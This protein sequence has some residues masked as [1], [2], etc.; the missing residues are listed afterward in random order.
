M[1]Y[2]QYTSEEAKRLSI[3]YLGTVVYSGRTREIWVDGKCI[4]ANFSQ[5]VEDL[6]AYV[7]E[8]IAKILGSEGLEKTLDT[9]KEIQDELLKNINYTVAHDLGNSE[10]EY[11]SVIREEYEGS[12]DVAAVYRDEELNVVATEDKD[13]NIVYEEGYG[14]LER[15]NVIDAL[16]EKINENKNQ[17]DILKSKGFV[18]NIS[19]DESGLVTT[20]VEETT[21]EDGVDSKNYTIGVK[22]GNF[23][24]G[25]GDVLNP[26]STAYTN[27]IATVKD[28]QDYIE[29]R[30]VWDEFVS[31]ADDIADAINNTSDSDSD[32]DIQNDAEL[33]DNM[34]F[35]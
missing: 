34:I 8:Q 12:E 27:G 21:D 32:Y 9:I 2:G 14:E 1:R 11:V 28:V 35:G 6:R 5:S 20:E 18:A 13:G 26:E 23:K 30:M 31:S 17:I 29:E 22:V 10:V 25:R 19:S 33:D 24:T 3:D 7:D 16:M 15:E 4:A